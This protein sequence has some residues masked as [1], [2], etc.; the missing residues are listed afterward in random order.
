MK[1]RDIEERDKKRREEN[2][3]QKGSE[4]MRTLEVSR[5]RGL[6]KLEREPQRRAKKQRV[7][8]EVG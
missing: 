3:Q 5:E 4:R 1:E 7:K 6:K 8:I 2:K